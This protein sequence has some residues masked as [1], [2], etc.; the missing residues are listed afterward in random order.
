MKFAKKLD[1]KIRRLPADQTTNVR[2]E[3]RNP[4]C[5]EPLSAAT[6]TH[7][8]FT[9]DSFFINLNLPK[10]FTNQFQPYLEVVEERSK[11]KCKNY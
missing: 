4:S 2:W 6:F 8:Y 11:L 5:A 9:P 1:L 7:H 10:Y 3:M